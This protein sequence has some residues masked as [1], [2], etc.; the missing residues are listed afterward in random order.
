METFDSLWD[1][2]TQ[3]KRLIPKKWDE[4]YGMLKNKKRNP[5]GGWMPALPLILGAWYNTMPIEKQLRF[6]EH[7]QYAVDNNQVDE[8]STYLRN[9]NEN[10]WY[11]FGDI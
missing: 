1:Y 2:C 6:K 9:L 10:D 11:H 5:S 4:L 8:I 7:I 3:N